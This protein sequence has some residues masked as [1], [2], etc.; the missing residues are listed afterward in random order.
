VDGRESSE[1]FPSA[2]ILRL[3][4]A[5]DDVEPNREI[6]ENPSG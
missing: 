4:L 5:E 6:N 3:S 1:K 2:R